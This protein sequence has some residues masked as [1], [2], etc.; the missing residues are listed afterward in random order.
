MET[1]VNT[2]ITH[3]QALLERIRTVIPEVHAQP[4]TGMNPREFAPTTAQAVV[5]VIYGG[6]SYGKP[7]AAAAQRRDMTFT[8]LIGS[9]NL[10]PVADGAHHDSY[11]VVEAVSSALAG[12]ETTGS[13]GMGITWWPVSDAFILEDLGVWWYSISFTGYDLYS[14]GG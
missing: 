10:R 11:S 13:D 3:E 14:V 2:R 1:T 6:T 9:R 8:L 4:L 7:S 12:Y 5:L